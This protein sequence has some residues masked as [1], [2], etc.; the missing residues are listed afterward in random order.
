MTWCFL[1]TMRRRT[2]TRDPDKLP[3]ELPLL[4]QL[5]HFEA[6]DPFYRPDVTKLSNDLAATRYFNTVNVES[7][8]PPDELSAGST[9]A[10]DNTANQ[11]DNVEDG[12]L[13]SD[14]KEGANVG[15]GDTDLIGES[16][17]NLSSE[18][19][20]SEVVAESLEANSG[21]T[22]DAADIAPIEFQVDEQTQNKLQE[23]K[24]KANRLS[25]LPNDRVLDEKDEKAEN[26]LGKSATQS[27]ILPRRYSLKK[28][29]SFL[30]RI[31]YRQL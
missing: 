8:L 25:R 6:G 17:D 30:M 5:L 29:K 10:F 12:D 28:K 20:N 1:R 4:R 3:V 23:I 13:D 15:A 2:F 18:E 16:R 7:L 21:A 27:V 11:S 31:L 9:L 22:V 14:V 26:F 24:A 19:D